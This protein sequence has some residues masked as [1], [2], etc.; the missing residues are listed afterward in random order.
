M[1]L[2]LLFLAASQLVCCTTSTSTTT[3][4]KGVVT[5][6]QTRKVDMDV[7]TKTADT[8]TVLADRYSGK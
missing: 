3:D 1:K 5:I 6:T 2:T 8:I 7:F 4:A